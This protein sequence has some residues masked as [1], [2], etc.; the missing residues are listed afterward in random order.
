MM[1][2]PEANFAM[3]KPESGCPIDMP[4]KWAEGYRKHYGEGQNFFSIPLSLS[5]DYTLEYLTHQFCVHQ[6]PTG[7]KNATQPAQYTTYWGP[8]SYCILRSG[9]KCPRG[10]EFLKL[11]FLPI[12]PVLSVYQTLPKYSKIR[13]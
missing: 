7:P 6:T 5:G 13:F 2:W 10:I 8:G 9:G 3:L 4:G 11:L 12:I 1:H